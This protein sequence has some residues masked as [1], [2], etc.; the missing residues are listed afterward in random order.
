V[1]P[2]TRISAAGAATCLALAGFAV[3]LPGT[4]AHAAGRSAVP[5][6][7]PS[8]ANAKALKGTAAA[9]D[10]VHLRVYLPWRNAAALEQVAHDVSTPGTASYGKFLTPAQF[11]S[12]YAPSAGSLSSVRNWLK[13]QGFSI[14]DTPD[15]GHYVAVEG[16]VAQAQSA[17]GT[18]LGL[19]SA[20]GRTLRA[21][22]SAPS[23]PAD[24]ASQVSAVV[25]LD[26]S[27]LLQ[28]PDNSTGSGPNQNHGA[29]GVGF[30][31]GTPCS[32]YQGEK[33]VTTGFSAYGTTSKPL[34]VCGYTPS[35]VRGLYGLSGSDTGAGQTV[36][37]VGANASPTLVQDVTQYS[38]LHGLP[39]PSIQ[40]LVAPGV[41]KHPDTP[42]QVPGDF[43]GEETLDAE[44]IH[45]TAPMAKLLFVGSSNAF[46]DFDVSIN[47]IVDRKLAPIISISYGFTG[48]GVPQ[49]FI[50]SLNATFLQ[51]RAT[52]IGVFVSSGDDGDDA[53]DFGGQ[54]AVDFY[55]DSPNVTAVGGTSVAIV[56]AAASGS[57]FTTGGAPTALDPR[58][59]GEPYGI[60]DPSSPVNK[61]GWARA[62]EVSW[63]TGSDAITGA[64]ISGSGTTY[65]LTGSPAKPVP[66]DFTSGGGGGVSRVFPQPD[67]QRGVTDA[68][69][70]GA[71]AFTGGRA[72]PD[73]SALADPNTGFLVGQTQTFSDGTYYDEYRLG[74]TSA[75]APLMAGMAAVLNQRNGGTALGFL[76]P[77][78]YQA[79]RT[80]AATAYYDVDQKD[81]F[82]STVSSPLPSV[83]RVNYA[84]S[85]SAAG[86]LTYFLRT[87]ESPQQ[88]LHS[89]R[90]YDTATGV[91][92]PN[93]NGFFTALLAAH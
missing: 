43:Y 4:P 40:E 90:G 29:P 91:G 33:T 79:Y 78:I 84:D 41:Y 87:F 59:H 34:A 24:L 22:E 32:T 60:D 6:S 70:D 65:T 57:G 92:T 12:A 61:P 56:P 52:G 72:V 81:L 67:Y 10:T 28:A 85:E 48:E 1:L 44:S 37:F 76:N 82:G 69:A 25:G 31:V 35:Q 36:A 86:G 53:I 58:A 17:F 9:G 39:D 13:S 27:P 89:V 93:G 71:S 63:Q 7:Q 20:Y 47:H 46:Q 73:I 30:R 66:G 14:A 45:T 64:T 3:V 16:T 49:G 38:R 74:G 51:A 21:P 23:V 68:A 50:N 15:N 77:V 54:T 19:Y 62:F 2:H 11:R 5:G 55:A 8:W 42:Q 83:V 75:A 88:T 80:A 18:T 26:D